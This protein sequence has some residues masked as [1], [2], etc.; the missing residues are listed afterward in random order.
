M[1]LTQF[2]WG[3]YVNKIVLLDFKAWEDFLKPSFFVYI[4]LDIYYSYVCA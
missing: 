4:V 3:A 2:L 1:N